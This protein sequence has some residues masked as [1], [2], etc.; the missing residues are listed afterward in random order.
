MILA[1][2]LILAAVVVTT[3]VLTNHKLTDELTQLKADHKQALSALQAK[4]DK[5]EDVLGKAKTRFGSFKPEDM[6]WLHE[7]GF[8]DTKG[9][10]K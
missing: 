9:E 8:I 2:V 10:K 3:V 6:K 1:C 7:N 4:A 5:A